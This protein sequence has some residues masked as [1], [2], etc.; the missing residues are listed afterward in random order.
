MNMDNLPVWY[1]SKLSMNNKPSDTK[2]DMQFVERAP[3]CQY[4]VLTNVD[5]RFLVQK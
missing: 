3:Q 4:M 1:N 5:F 2:L